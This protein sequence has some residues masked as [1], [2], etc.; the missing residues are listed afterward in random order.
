MPLNINHTERMIEIFQSN[1]TTLVPASF[2]F[3][4]LPKIFSH[5]PEK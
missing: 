1:N 3:W 2:T 5:M 4:F